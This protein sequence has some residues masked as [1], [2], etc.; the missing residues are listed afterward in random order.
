MYIYIYMYIHT[1]IHVY[2]HIY[3]YVY[4]YVRK[5]NEGRRINEHKICPGCLMYSRSLRSCGKVRR[6]SGTRRSNTRLCSK[7]WSCGKVGRRRCWGRTRTYVRL[8]RGVVSCKVG[9]VRGKPCLPRIGSEV[10]TGSK[11]NTGSKVGNMSKVGIVRGKVCL[12]QH[13]IRSKVS[14]REQTS[15]VSNM[16]KARGKPCLHRRNHREWI[17]GK[18]TNWVKWVKCEANHACADADQWIKGVKWVKCKANHTCADAEYAP[19]SPT[20][21]LLCMWVVKWR[22]K[23]LWSKLASL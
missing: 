16:S 7:L 23:S 8:T 19:P 9:E 3:T 13:R 6:R 20:S 22:G 17:W 11:V 10:S 18:C 14:K 21:W 5:R 2:I 4:I 1:Y 15:K 12:C